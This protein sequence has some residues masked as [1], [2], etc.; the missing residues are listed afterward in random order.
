MSKPLRT[1]LPEVTYHCFSR[2]QGLNKLLFDNFAKKCFMDAIE[3]CQLKYNFELNAAEIVGNHFHLVI[4]TL[5]DEETISRIMQFIKARTAEMYNRATGRKGPFWNERFG[6]T[7]LEESDN[8]EHYLFTLLWYIAFNPVRK[9]ESKD[10]RENYISFIRCYLKDLKEGFE[11]PIKITL[12]PYFY[13]LG[14]SFSE[15]AKRL[16]FYE[17]AYRK[18]MALYF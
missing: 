18:R 2:C 5:Q 15:C 3:M 16:L 11:L 10:P 13:R 9:G 4:R 17:D 8:P 12:H 14:D 7:I 1:I 6:S